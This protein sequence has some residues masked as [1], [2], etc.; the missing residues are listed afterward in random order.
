MKRAKA[1][2]LWFMATFLGFLLGFLLG[3]ATAKT[4]LYLYPTRPRKKTR[5]FIVWV[6][7]T[8]IIFLTGY[9]FALHMKEK[10]ARSIVGESAP[11]YPYDPRLIRPTSPPQYWNPNTRQWEQQGLLIEPR[12]V[13]KP[14]DVRPQG[15]R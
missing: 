13:I 8:V 2:L 6:C 14:R 11:I 4:H 12:E 9:Y 5:V 10:P 3:R 7:V 1:I 15:R